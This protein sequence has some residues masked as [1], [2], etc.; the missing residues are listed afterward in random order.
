MS[1]SAKFH[2][3]GKSCCR[4]GKMQKLTARFI[5]FNTRVSNSNCS[6][7]QMRTYKVTRGQMYDADATMAVLKP[8]LETT[9]TSYFLRKVS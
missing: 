5:I 9:F 6:E 7:G 3:V 4:S 1:K 2:D 8:N